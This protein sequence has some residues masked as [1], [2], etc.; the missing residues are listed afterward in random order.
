MDGF[1]RSARLTAAA[2]GALW[3]AGCGS[4]RGGEMTMTTGTGIPLPTS[5]A[6]N[7]ST[8]EDAV[9]DGG[10]EKLDS[11]VDS[12]A[13]S[14][15]DGGDAD[16]CVGVDILFIIDN[17]LSMAD[18]QAALTAAFPN[19]ADAMWAALP[20]G[21]SLHVGVTT[22][23]GFWAGEN[24]ESTTECVSDWS[25][26]VLAADFITPMAGD[27]AINGERGQLYE[28]EGLRYFDTNTDADP[29]ELATWFSAAA[30]R[31][32]NGT[33]IEF[34]AAAAGWTLD[35]VR[36]DVNAGFLR[37]EGAVL[38]LFFI[39]DE[40]DKSPEPIDPYVQKVLAA[41]SECGGADCILTAGAVPSYCYPHA[42]DTTLFDFMNAFGKPPASVGFIP[43]S[44][45]DPPP[46]QPDYSAILG[47]A[48]AD[49][50]AEACESLVP[51]G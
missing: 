21:I 18:D 33:N 41:K 12:T 23:S 46:P 31:G 34:H 42:N 14:A 25:D 35:P 49:V 22:T 20:E 15:D 39:T 32:E 19:F 43:E 47:E 51:E 45:L 44:F 27:N 13:G 7:D 5:S 38:V 30:Q 26:P 1:A 17:S 2:A 11:G 36:A 3:V 28:H 6:G 4:D 10:T 9:D 40:P 37:D 8:G 48:L 29:S 16:M 50:I 24:S